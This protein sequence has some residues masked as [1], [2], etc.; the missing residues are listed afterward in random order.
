[1]TVF[2]RNSLAFMDMALHWHDGDTRYED[3]IVARRINAWRDIFPP[4]LEADL[5]GCC[6]GDTV[7]RD[8][9]PGTLT[10]AIDKAKIHSIPRSRFTSRTIA[11]R[12]IEPRTGRFYPQGMFEGI[13]GVYPGTMAPLRIVNMDEHAIRVD[14]N[15]PL[16]GHALRVEATL[17]HLEEKRSE[18]G[19]SLTH[20]G[21]ELCDN[22]PGMQARPKGAVDFFTPDFFTRSDEDD[23]SFYAHPRLTHH[24]DMQAHENLKRLYRRFLAPGMR[25]LDLMASIDSHLPDGMDLQVTGL[26]MNR[27]ELEQNPHLDNHLVHDL[28]AEAALPT[29]ETFDAITCSLSIEYLTDPVS[30]LRSARKRLAPGGIL[31]VSFSDRW[32]PTKAVRGWLDLHPF[33]RVGLVRELQRQ[34]GFAGPSGAISIRNDWRPQDDPHFLETR[35]ISDPIHVVWTRKG[36]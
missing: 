33:E 29:A 15:H 13:P 26:G 22:G 2:G 3:R 27:E 8:Y 1:M 5:A 9:G 25:V 7:S 11:G 19:G 30:V 12:S 17:T 24:V 16:A 10:P 14:R 36:E 4:R 18:T 34:A 35:G 32:F 6:I 23:A 20:W 21:E 31:L 28:N